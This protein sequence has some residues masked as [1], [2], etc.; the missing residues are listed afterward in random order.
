MLLSGIQGKERRVLEKQE[1][2]VK[3]GKADGKH[4]Q[5]RSNS[6]GQSTS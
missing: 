3:V 6:Q 5:G 1:I 2:V 4:K